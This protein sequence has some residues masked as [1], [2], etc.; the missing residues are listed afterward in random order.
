MKIVSIISYFFTVIGVVRSNYQE[1]YIDRTIQEILQSV[2][3]H[4]VIIRLQKY[5]IYDGARRLLDIVARNVATTWPSQILVSGGI[6]GFGFQPGDLASS[7]TFLIY[8][9]ATN[10]M[11]NVAELNDMLNDVNSI[12]HPKHTPKL[13]LIIDSNTGILDARSQLEYLWEQKIFDVIILEVS[14]HPRSSKPVLVAI[15]RFNGFNEDYSRVGIRELTYD[16]GTDWYPNK[17]QNMYGNAFRVTFEDVPPYG[18]FANG[19]AGGLAKLFSIALSAAVNGTVL[20]TSNLQETDVRYNAEGLVYEEWYNTQ[21]EHTIPVD[22]DR[23]CALVPAVMPAAK[24]L[25]DFWQ[26]I[27]TIV[28]GFLLTAVVWC[29]SLIVRVNER[30]RN[31]LNTIRLLL[32]MTP[33]YGPHSLVEK[34]LFVAV[35]ITATEYMIIFQAELLE[36]VVEFTVNTRVST[37]QDLYNTGLKVVVSP[38]MHD[39]LATIEELSPELAKRFVSTVDYE[40]QKFGF[41]AKYIDEF[42]KD[43]RNERKN[44]LTLSDHSMYVAFFVVIV[45]HIISFIVFLGELIVDQFF[46][47]KYYLMKAVRAV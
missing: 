6:M 15:H 29:V 31:P 30:I 13:L 1:G 5:D 20:H 25:V 43:E 18:T 9:Y 22:D 42:W 41:M 10:D 21:H 46:K 14:F 45:G 32:G 36:F 7:R 35:L 26:I 11:I 37:F 4:D 39:E 17:S 44:E 33:L 23:V 38:V 12:S 27:I 16:N 28:F 19:T 8:I 34:I 47:W 2:E 24:V 3:P 40:F